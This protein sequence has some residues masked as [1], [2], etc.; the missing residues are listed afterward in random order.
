MSKPGDPIDKPPLSPTEQAA[1]SAENEKK[2]NPADAIAAFQNKWKSVSDDVIQGRLDTNQLKDVARTL[3]TLQAATGSN[4]QNVV[5]DIVKDCKAKNI[6]DDHLHNFVSA[7]LSVELDIEKAKDK[8]STGIMRDSRTIAG[9]LLKYEVEKRGFAPELFDIVKNKTNKEVID[10]LID[11]KVPEYIKQHYRPIIEHYKGVGGAGAHNAYTDLVFNNISSEMVRANS[12]AYNKLKDKGLAVSHPDMV[13]AS[14]ENTRIR[15]KMAE[16]SYAAYPSRGDKDSGAN[17]NPAF[18]KAGIYEALEKQFDPNKTKQQLS[19]EKM[20]ELKERAYERD[21]IQKERRQALDALSP[22][23]Q[24]KPQVVQKETKL[25]TTSKSFADRFHDVKERVSHEVG[26]VSEQVGVKASTVAKEIKTAGKDAF[27]QAE[28]QVRNSIK[29]TKAS[30][31]DL[32]DNVKSTVSAGS[33][34]TKDIK[35]GIDTNSLPS[36]VAKRVADIMK[37]SVTHPAPQPSPKND[38]KQ[39]HPPARPG[40][41]PP[42]RPGQHDGGISH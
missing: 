25:D 13:K 7:A 30:A 21:A 26:K 3:L 39:S 29:D 35:T 37:Y 27:K 31:T 8:G 24:D 42:L 36:P 6:S 19:A 9:P 1:K 38:S 14:Q 16:M 40:S 18:A 34:L 15:T 23:T 28:T 17:P 22:Q 12:E 2:Q 20:H 4:A 5:K 41:K 11:I 33:K 32:A 10:A